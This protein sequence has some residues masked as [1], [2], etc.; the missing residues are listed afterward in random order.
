MT[1]TT[2]PRC[3]VI[4]RSCATTPGEPRAGAG[5]DRLD[6]RLYREHGVGLWL[7]TLRTAGE[8]VGDRGLTPS[9]STASPS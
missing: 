8:F 7:L 6:H 9:R 2:W 5:L 3:W 1:W 4:R